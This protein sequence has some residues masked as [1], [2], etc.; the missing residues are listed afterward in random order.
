MMEEGKPRVQSLI[1]A[2]NR[3]P[4]SVKKAADGS[5]DLRTSAG[6]SWRAVG[7]ADVRHDLGRMAG[8]VRRGRT[9]ARRAHGH[10]AEQNFAVYLTKSQVELY[11]NGYCN[12]V[13]WSLFHYVPLSFEAK[14]SE[15]TNMHAQWLAYKSLIAPSATPF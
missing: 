1:I 11:Y 10:F 7:R 2:A 9:G 8:R 13:L 12:N 3:L 15:D 4:I 6:D 14:L 5:W